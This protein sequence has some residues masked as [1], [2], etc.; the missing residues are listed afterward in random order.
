[1]TLILFACG[2]GTASQEQLPPKLNRS[3]WTKHGH[4]WEGI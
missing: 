4:V 2:S 1:M 3:G